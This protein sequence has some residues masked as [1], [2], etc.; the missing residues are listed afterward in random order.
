[1]YDGNQNFSN[2]IRPEDTTQNAGNQTLN[3]TTGTQ[4]AYGDTRPRYGSYN[5]AGSGYGSQPGTY[6]QAP[7][8][9]PEAPKK[10]NHVFGKVMAVVGLGLLF[11][12]V[13]SA[14]FLGVKSLSELLEARLDRTKSTVLESDDTDIARTD[15]EA[16]TVLDEEGT[17]VTDETTG[18]LSSYIESNTT[19]STTS[20]LLSSFAQDTSSAAVTA[21]DV[22]DVVEAV[23]PSVVSV[24]NYYTYTGYDYFFGSTTSEE[25]A[26]A[27]SGFI[28]AQNDGELLIVT[29]YHVIEGAEELSVQFIDGT[30]A[31]AYVK[32]TASTKDLA[33]I[34]VNISDLSEETLE[35]IAIATLGDSDSLRVGETAIAIG[36]ALGYGQSVTTGVISALNREM[37]YEDY[38]GEYIQTDAAINPGNSGGALLNVNGEVIGINSSKIGGSTVE[39]MGYAI[40]ISDAIPIIEELMNA[41][42]K[43]YL[44]ITGASLTEEIVTQYSIPADGGVCV[45]SAVSGGAAANGGITSGDIITEFGGTTIS[46][47]DELIE[48]LGDYEGGDQVTIKY[49]HQKRNGTWVEQETTV[50]LGYNYDIG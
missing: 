2:G 41:E 5:Y 46:T 37:T 23:M 15:N 17:D 9:A 32:G 21:L 48:T 31:D 22:S 3:N 39:G 34:S 28:V 29:N 44:G 7:Y 24:T 35:S 36:N 40:P 26:S 50:T 16:A 6:Q 27:G 20:Q 30:E 10:K 45:I 8:H 42:P 18:D 12:L 14:A 25:A 33:V 47:M 13:A 38:T 1:M 43:S 4:G 19:L 49:L 11:G